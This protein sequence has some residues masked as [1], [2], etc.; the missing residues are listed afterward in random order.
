MFVACHYDSDRLNTAII[1]ATLELMV[2]LRNN[3]FSFSMGMGLV[4]ECNVIF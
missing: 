4:F 2:F 1:F 3:I